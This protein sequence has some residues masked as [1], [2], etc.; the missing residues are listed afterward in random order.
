MSVGSRGRTLKQ[1]SVT[2]EARGTHGEKEEKRNVT[3]K[4]R[5]NQKGSNVRGAQEKGERRLDLGGWN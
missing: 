2:A 4:V 3:S 1:L 5:G